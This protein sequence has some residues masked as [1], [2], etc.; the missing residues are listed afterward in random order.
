VKVLMPEYNFSVSVIIPVYNAGKF[1]RKAVESALQQPEVK[2]V[3]LVED[4][5][6][7]NSLEVCHQIIKDYPQKIKLYR[8]EGGVNKGAGATRNLGMEVAQQEYLSFLDADDYFLET[9]F[10]RTREIFERYPNADGVYE[11]VGNFSDG[12]EKN[13]KLYTVNRALPPE[14]LF[15]YLLRGTYGHF[16][17][18]GLTFRKS[19]LKKSGVFESSLRLHQDSELWL[20]FAFHGCLYGG[21]LSKPVTMVRRHQNNRIT[22]A[23]SQSRLLFWEVVWAYF[24]KRRVNLSDRVLIQWKYSKALSK[25]SGSPTVMEFSR[26]IFKG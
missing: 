23:N 26:F 13:Y 3:I 22:H 24:R 6:P 9:R 25:I 2:E 15:H 5:S 12:D 18:N 21:E 7:D 10:S 17:T 8:H 14:R 4:A 19:L 20:R 11:A 1:V 16:S